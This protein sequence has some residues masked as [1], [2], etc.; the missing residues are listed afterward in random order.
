MTT[1]LYVVF[2]SIQYAAIFIFHYLPSSTT[3]FSASNNE[4]SKYMYVILHPVAA[5]HHGAPGQMTWL[6][7]PQPWILLW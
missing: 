7:N 5:L 2:Y 4:N 3:F 1:M 6:E